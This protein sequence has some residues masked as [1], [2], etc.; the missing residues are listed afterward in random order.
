MFCKKC[1]IEQIDK[2]GSFCAKCGEPFE[3]LKKKTQ[4]SLI[5]FVLSFFFL[6]GNLSFPGFGFDF[7]GTDESIGYNLGVLLWYLVFALSALYLVKKSKK[8]DALLDQDEKD[9]SLSKK[10]QLPKTLTFIV[11]ATLVL[12]GIGYNTYSENKPYNVNSMALDALYGTNV[13]GENDITDALRGVFD[14]YKEQYQLQ[15]SANIALDASNVLEY[16]SFETGA[17]LT[18]S[19][20]LLRNAIKELEASDETQET[21]KESIREYIRQLDFSED[22][23][24]EMLRGFNESV[25]NSE[26]KYLINR[27]SELL[28]ESYTEMLGLYNFLYANF[29]D[30]Y[31]DFDEFGE[32]NIFIYSDENIDT[33]NKYMKDIGYSSLR[34]QES[35]Q[36]LFDYMNERL[37]EQGIDIT[38][39]EAYETLYGF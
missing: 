25:N 11:L 35:E 38:A 32:E 3:K 13:S 28:V 22:F 31:I 14:K 21:I 8:E 15:F 30:Y 39:E 20:N 36:A 37:T 33:Y 2:K 1:G 18:K 27:R 16:D 6:L 4:W 29:N 26:K 5:F 23:K 12:V 17:E 24:L 9:D 10:K 34:F 7:S 19:I